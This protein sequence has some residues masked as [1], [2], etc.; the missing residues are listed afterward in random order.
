MITVASVTPSS[1]AEKNGIKAGDEIL[2]IN[3]REIND[4]LDYRFEMMS[5]TLHIVL[6][7]GVEEINISVTKSEYEELGAEAETYL[8]AEKKRCKNACMFCFIDQNPHGM[9]ESIYF[10]DDDERLS[11]LQGN[12]V[13][14]TNLKEKDIDRIIE[15]HISP[16]NVS[17]HTMN[18]ALRV[19]M[20][21]NKNAGDVLDYLPRLAEGGIEINAQL[22]LCPGIN[23]G[24]ELVYS[25]EQL[26][27]LSTL[28]SVAAVPVGLTKHREGLCALSTFTKEGA[29]KVIETIDAFGEKALT[30]RGI[31]T[32][33]SSDEF[34]LKASLPLPEE[35]YYEDYPQIENGVGM[36]RD[37]RESFLYAFEQA[38]KKKRPYN[39]VSKTLV[40]GVAS[41]E[42]IKNLVDM[43]VGAY[44]EAEIN[45]CRVVNNFFGENVTVSGL[46]TGGDIVSQAKNLGKI[47][48]LPENV[49]KSD[50]DIF[51]DNMTVSE[52]K[53]KLK[54]E[55]ILTTGD[56]CDLLEAL[57][58]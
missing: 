41:Y 54:V 7:R 43:F 14:L 20:M 51:L 52:M 12:Y 37:H 32:F 29:K 2:Y 38:K 48:L 58:I 46:L 3:G 24:D 27:S 39:G 22:V 13:T 30:E 8:M 57:F 26:Y 33:Y 23:D 21:K 15:M 10:K 16:V 42:H 5:E 56:G 25:L 19:Q 34:Y 50:E 1:I 40:T 6:K 55:K 31:R 53:E 17:V 28:N 47:L 49:L 35:N 45:V 18:K 36:L 9:R 44:P 4:V 11:F